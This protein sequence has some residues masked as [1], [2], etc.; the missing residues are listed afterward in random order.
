MHWAF[1][2]GGANSRPMP[3][4]LELW[5]ICVVVKTVVLFA[6]PQKLGAVLY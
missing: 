5:C 3:G 6:V 1:D 4:L 2:L